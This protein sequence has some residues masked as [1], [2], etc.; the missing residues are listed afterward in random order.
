MQTTVLD[1]ELKTHFLNLYF[2]ALS[3][4]QIDTQELEMLF[5]LGQ[6]R[7]IQKEEIEQIILQP[8]S[9][10]FTIPQ[11][12]VTKIEYLYDYVTMILADGK[13]DEHE[14]LTLKKFCLKFGFDE[15]NVPAIMQFLIEEAMNGTDKREIIEQVKQTL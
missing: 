11:D 15:R 9:T 2:L 10:K 5:K 7:G 6:E 4:T 3:D 14:H 8:D 1:H 13:V 12:T